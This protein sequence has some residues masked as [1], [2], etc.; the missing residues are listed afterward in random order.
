MPINL[1]LYSVPLLIGFLQGIVCAVL[2]VVRGYQRGRLSDYLL[3]LLLLASCLL[4]LPYMLG[5]MGIQVMWNELLFFPADPALLIGPII[6]F[7][8]VAQT[9]SDFRFGRQDL[10]HA[11][12]FGVFFLYHLAVFA[13]G[14]DFTQWW[15]ANADLPY[16]SVAFQAATLVSNYYYL[17]RSIR[18]YHQYRRWIETQYSDVEKISFSWYRNYLYMVAFS[19]TL[20]WVFNL[21]NLLGLNLSYTQNWWEYFIISVAVYFVAFVGYAQTP[22]RRLLFTQAAKTE[23]TAKSAPANNADIA[24]WTHRI[25]QVLRDEK[26]YLNPE[27][28]L[29]DLAKSLKVSN[30]ILSQ[31]I[32][33]GLGKNFNDLINE[34]RV[35]RFKAEVR[36]EKNRNLTLLGI[37][38]NCGFNSKATFNRAF[39]KATGMTP[40]EYLDTQTAQ[41]AVPAPH[42]V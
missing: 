39:K 16:L 21:L 31:A 26:P 25:T 23:E 19:I 13:Q 24:A 10:R 3:S 2:L 11:V 33:T 27:L 34:C 37:A 38:L 15:M 41:P 22:T 29:G 8:L 28:T 30:A 35:E 5:F 9:N 7:Y 32:N 12:P 17:Y 1:N 42:Q 18:Y 20:S 36:E 4:I 6:Y 40:R 14:R